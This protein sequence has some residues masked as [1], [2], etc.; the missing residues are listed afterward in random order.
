MAKGPWDA[1]LVD[2]SPLGPD[3]KAA[4]ERIRQSSP[5]AALVLVTG[6]ADAVPADVDDPNMHLVR[7]PFEVSEVL[8]LLRR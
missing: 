7:K 4:I 1:V 5:E 3:P 2:L 6:Q 8:A